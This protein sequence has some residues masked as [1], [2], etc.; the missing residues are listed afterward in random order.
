MMYIISSCVV[1][2][3]YW[4]FQ[5]Y[6]HMTLLQRNGFKGPK[7]N[8]FLGRLDVF[9]NKNNVKSIGELLNQYGDIVAFYFGGYPAL[10]VQDEELLNNI[11]I[12]DFHLFSD[13]QSFGSGQYASDIS[14]SALISTVGN[15]WR[16]MRGILTPTFTSGKLKH[17][18]TVMNESIGQ[19]MDNL[20]KETDECKKEVNIHSSFQGLTMDAIGRSAFGIT[21]N[22]AGKVHPLITASRDVFNGKGSLLHAIVI[23]LPGLDSILFPIRKLVN[24]VKKNITYIPREFIYSVCNQ[25]LAARRKSSETHADLLQALI[26]AGDDNKA[27]SKKLVLSDNEIIAN[28]FLFLEAGFETT[29]TTL[30]YV[31]HVLVNHQEVQDKLRQEIL[32]FK[33][34]NKTDS[35]SYLVMTELPYMDAVIHETLRMYQPVTNFINRVASQDYS[36]QGKTIP[37]GTTIFV[38]APQIHRNAKFWPNPDTFDPM[39]FYET[40]VNPIHFMAFGAGPRN[41][42]GMRFA[43]ARNEARFVQTVINIPT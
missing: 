40:K 16:N 22:Q 13:R 9:N 24:M 38:P 34:K 20:T 15:R 36:Y 3:A 41:C 27:S 12:K 11:L 39:R 17:M 25:L 2:A 32:N 19:L 31:A 28:S 1:L 43:D 4:L 23:Y 42:I 37:K 5:R 29:S 33:A 6:R 26:E 10:I 14:R 35:D 21:T 7:N 30:A 18:A 8:I